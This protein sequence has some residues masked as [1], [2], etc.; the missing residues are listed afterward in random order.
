[1][2]Y[3]AELNLLQNSMRK[4]RINTNIVHLDKCID[5]SIDN[6]LRLLIDLK[7]EY[8]KTFGEMFGD[9]EEKTVYTYTDRFLGSYVFFCL[10]ESDGDILLIGPFLK[11]LLSKEDIIILSEQLKIDKKYLK[12]LENYYS[13]IPFVADSGIFFNLIDAFCESI[14]E[15]KR[16]NYAELQKESSS[17]L[18]IL[19]NEENAFE[20]NE[21][22]LLNMKMMETRYAFENELINAVSHGQIQA[23]ENLMSNFTEISFE[24]RLNDKLRNYKNYAIIM[25]TLLRKA[26]ES[27]G[28]HPLYIDK[29]SSGF[30][31]D[32]EETRNLSTISA[33]M[34][35]ILRKY[36]S[37]VKENSIKSFSAPVQK[38]IISIDSDLTA[39]LSLNHLAEIQNISPAYLSNIFHKETGETLTEFVNKKRIAYARQL[40]DTTNLQIQTIAQRCGIVDVHYFSRIF[41]KYVDKTPKEYRAQSRKKRS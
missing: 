28:V 39:N 4:C 15:T 41:K 12:L 8:K 2:K 7:S 18:P 24:E 19:Q 29:V 5:S 9:I 20:D 23:V 10:S 40:L 25:N 35:K 1:M 34:S 22:T 6:G 14:W 30:A 13:G 21:K 31:R 27:G 38:A 32:I 36:C 16:V 33:L 11:T 17:S 3:A 37:L 26:A